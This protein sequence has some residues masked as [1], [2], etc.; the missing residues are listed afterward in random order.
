M[1]IAAYVRRRRMV[2]N[3]KR[4][5]LRIGSRLVASWRKLR[6]STIVGESSLVE[7]LR[8][9]SP[10]VRW[11]AAADLGRNSARSPEA[12]AALIAA[13][14]DAE[15]FVRWRAAEALASQETSRVFPLLVAALNDGTSLQRAGAA[16]ALSGLGG[17]AVSLALRGHV[18]DADAAVRAAASQG[19]GASADSNVLLMLVDLLA[20]AD[21]DVRRAAAS[22]LGRLGDPSAA[23][24]LATAL[25][26]TPQS[27][28]VR[29]AIAA[30][31]VR[32]AHPD[33]QP[34]LLSALGD[35]DPQVRGYAADALGQIG[36]ETSQAALAA[37]LNDQNAL[38]HGVVGDRARH[39]LTLL[40]RRGRRAVAAAD[41]TKTI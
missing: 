10:R 40:E 37:L 8:S 9:A 6:S 1:S 22:S 19:L 5:V 34:A 17:E 23:V 24:A 16:A 41:P 15:P 11:E 4:W 38:L 36:D 27:L 29:R 33:A 21:P 32:T 12:I 26:A 14:G 28:L 25:T 18:T 30:A 39:A 7:G 31:L 20:D 35:P 2:S 13:L 3:M